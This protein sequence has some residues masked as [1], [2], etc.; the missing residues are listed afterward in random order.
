[1]GIARLPTRHGYSGIEDTLR[2]IRLDKRRRSP[3]LLCLSRARPSGKSPHKSVPVS[4]LENVNEQH[5]IDPSLIFSG[6]VVHV[7]TRAAQRSA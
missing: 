1:M 6:D 4:T 5:L 7:P 2:S 3:S